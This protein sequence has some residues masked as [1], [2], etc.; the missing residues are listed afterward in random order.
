MIL[1]E[2]PLFFEKLLMWIEGNISQRLTLETVSKKSG[3]SK[4]HLQREFQQCYGMTLG[5]YIRRRRLTVAAEMLKNTSLSPQQIAHLCKWHSQ[6]TFSRGFKK[7]FGE[8][9][10]KWRIKKET[11]TLNMQSTFLKNQSFAEDNLSTGT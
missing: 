1:S 10:A 6:Q 11:C 4:F 2:N 5:T 8:P 9:P 7:Q 3:Y